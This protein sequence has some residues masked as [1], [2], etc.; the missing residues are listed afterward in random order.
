MAKSTKAEATRVRPN[1][2]KPSEEQALSFGDPLDKIVEEMAER[3][4][5]SLW[6]AALSPKAIGIQLGFNDKAKLEYL[7]KLATTGRHAYSAGCVG[8]CR[9]TVNTHKNKDPIFAAAIEEALEYFRDLLQGELVRRGVHGY[10]EEVLGG[11]NKDTIYKLKKH[12]D[13]CLEL[14]GRIHIP[15]MNTQRLASTANQTTIDNSQNMVVNNNFD[16]ETMPAADLAMFKVLIKNQAKR[17]AEALQIEED[18]TSIIEGIIVK[19]DE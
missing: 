6:T 14:L 2:I 19:D 10:T 1:Q 9:S 17:E 7:R 13:R 4:F 3:G 15:A 8:V 5:T 18:K 16:L 12:S 11:R